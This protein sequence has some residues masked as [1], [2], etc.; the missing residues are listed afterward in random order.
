MIRAGIERLTQSGVGGC[1]VLGEPAYYARFG[2]ENDP[3]LRL[4]G[5]PAEYFMR[6]VIAGTV[7]SGVVAYHEGFNAT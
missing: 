2:F 4:E 3:G 1:V 7:P 6:L 5:V